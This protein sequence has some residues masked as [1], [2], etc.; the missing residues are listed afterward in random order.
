MCGH[1]V[2]HQCLTRLQVHGTSILCPFDRQP[3]EIGDSG[4]WGLKKNFA[5]LELLEKL[6]FTTQNASNI[7]LF[8]QQNLDKEKEVVYKTDVFEFIM[9]IMQKIKHT[10][11]QPAFISKMIH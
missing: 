8:A 10:S 5:L 4:V 6:Q 2:C 9:I 7:N 11:I 1:T 3:T